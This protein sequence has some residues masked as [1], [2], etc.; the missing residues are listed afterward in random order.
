MDYIS[1]AVFSVK[2]INNYDQT[3]SLFVSFWAKRTVKH[4]LSK[5]I[6][7]YWHCMWFPISSNILATS[8][9]FKGFTPIAVCPEKKLVSFVKL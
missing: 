9:H 8:E 7:G 1:G 5:S 3:Y 2:Y 6:N 4:I